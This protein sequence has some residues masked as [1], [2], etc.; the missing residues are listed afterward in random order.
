MGSKHSHE[1]G[2]Y[3]VS[4]RPVAKFFEST[5]EVVVNL[6]ASPSSSYFHGIGVNEAIQGVAIIH[7]TTYGA[8]YQCALQ[9]VKNGG[10]HG[11]RYILLSKHEVAIAPHHQV[12]KPYIR[13]FASI[14]QCIATISGATRLILEVARATVT[15]K[16]L[17]M[18]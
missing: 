4:Q 5:I 8:L 2:D 13:V 3:D 6:P 7:Q 1:T 18:P 16:N 10:T 17:V 9:R 11:W 15:E 14:G 12:G